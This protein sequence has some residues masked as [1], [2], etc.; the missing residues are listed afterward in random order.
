M[1][2]P[3]MPRFKAKNPG[4]ANKGF[5]VV[6]VGG[7]AGG[8]DAYIRLL[9]CLPADMGVAIVI[10][11]HL[12][13]VATLLHEILP[14]YTEMPVEL[15][16]EGL[17]LQPNHVFIIPAQRD[18]H[19]LNGEFRLKPI[20]KPR[21]W[22]DVITVFLH[23]LTQ[24][25]HGKLIAVIV[26]GYDGDGAA[27]LRGIKEAGGITIAQKLETAAAPDMPES[28]IATGCID[29]VLSPEDIAQEIVRIAHQDTL[30]TQ[31]DT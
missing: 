20:S 5:P 7:S 9:Q 16:T 22:P 2:K 15:I 27:A 28:A 13:R 17:V 4:I 11:N 30:R 18:L 24:H 14:R 8:L 26:S 6:C 12:R 1:N 31:S 10:V 21:G 23:S 29:F 19:V 3:T 25:W